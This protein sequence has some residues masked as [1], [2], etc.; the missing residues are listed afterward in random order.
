[1]IPEFDGEIR[2]AREFEGARRFERLGGAMGG[3][4]RTAKRTP[5]K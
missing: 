4:I 1:M 2:I 5:G 3:T